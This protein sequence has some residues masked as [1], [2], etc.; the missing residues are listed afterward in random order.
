VRIVVDGDSDERNVLE[1]VFVKFSN[2]RV[3]E[4]TR[5]KVIMKFRKTFDKV[6]DY[7]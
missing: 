3:G 6:W 1:T 5:V 7:S 4:E 2:E